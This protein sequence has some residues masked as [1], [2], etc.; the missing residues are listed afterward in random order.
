MAVERLDSKVAPET[1]YYQFETPRDP[2][3]G[4]SPV[5]RWMCWSYL[6]TDQTASTISFFVPPGTR[7]VRA[8]HEVGVALT[9]AT[10]MILGDG[11]ATNGWIRT[12]RITPG[13]AGDFIGD[14]GSTYAAQGGKLYQTGD[15]L[16]L[17]FTG[18]T[19]AGAGKVYAEVIS[20]N[21]AITAT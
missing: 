7:M 18:V 6:H 13:T 1:A 17:A 19:S 21:E 5:T 2:E 14:L 4:M 11:D 15:T 10:A 9:G 3:D 12:G 16:D 8:I 20:Y